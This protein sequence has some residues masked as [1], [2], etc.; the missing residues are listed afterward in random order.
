MEF[1]SADQAANYLGIK[2]STLYAYVSRGLLDS[3]PAPD[4][5]R[6]R[7]YRKSDLDRLKRRSDAH[8]GH[9][10]AAADALDWGAPSLQTAISKITYAGPAYRGR[11]ARHL[12]RDGVGYEAVAEFLWSGDMSEGPVRWGKRD[13]QPVEL[14]AVVPT[15]ADSVD[16]LRVAVMLAGMANPARFGATESAQMRV[17]QQLIDQAVLSLASHRGASVEPGGT[18]AE[19]LAG[20]FGA[21]PSAPIREALQVALV[22]IADHELNAS[23]FSARVAASAGADLYACVSAA[24]ATLTGPRHGGACDRCEALLDK[25]AMSASVPQ[26]LMSRIRR[27][28]SLAGFDHPLY[29]HGDPRFPI[30]VRAAR[31][32]D[33]GAVEQ[34]ERLVDTAAQM[35]LGAPTVDLGLALLARAMALPAGAAKTI[36]AV[37][38]MAGWIAHAFEQRQQGFLLRPRARYVGD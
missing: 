33:D 34:V 25:V 38:R 16:V 12:V 36:F 23:T 4:D 27:G 3:V 37:G 31:P 6:R 8:G 9:A 14:A 26:V 11:L 30:L 21:A 17:A 35:E 15:S 24:L 18:V 20:A 19:R 32:F 28:D 22:V 1:Y 29:P 10:A 5:S 2:P 13:R 7:R